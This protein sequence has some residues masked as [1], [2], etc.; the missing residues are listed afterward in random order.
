MDGRQGNGTGRRARVRDLAL[1]ALTGILTL[2][3]PD[4]VHALE[5]SPIP[6]GVFVCL[7]V[8]ALL[9]VRALG[10]LRR[11]ARAGVPMRPMRPLD[12]EPLQSPPDGPENRA[13]PGAPAPSVTPPSDRGADSAAF[14]QAGTG[15]PRRLTVWRPDGVWSS[16]ESWVPITTAVPPPARIPF[17]RNLVIAFAALVLVLVYLRGEFFF[18]YDLFVRSLGELVYWPLPWPG[19]I[20][21]PTPTMVQPDYIFLMYVALLVAFL[22]ASGALSSRR[23]TGAQRGLLLALL[24]LYLPA[25]ALVDVTYFTIQAPFSASA[26]FL[27]RGFVGGTFFTMIL[28]GTVVLPPPLRLRQPRRRD[29]R[30]I[31]TFVAAGGLSILVGAWVLFVLFVFFGLGRF[32]VPFAV[33]LLL[34]LLALVVFGLLG[35]ALYDLELAGHPKVPLSVY[36]PPVTIIIPAYNEA[37]GI[38]EAIRSADAAA[39]HYPGEVELLV[40]NDGS[41]DRTSEIARAEVAALRHMHGAVVDLPHGG[42]SNALNGALRVARGEIVVRLDA[43]SRLSPTTGFGAIVGHFNN[44]RVGGVQGMILPLQTTGWTRHLRMMEIAWAHLFLRRGLMATRTAQVVDGAFCAFRRADLLAIGGWVPWNGE[45]TEVTLRLQRAGFRMRFEPDATAY[46]DV[47]EN[48]EALRRQR[49]RW[50]R[51]G[52]FAHQRHIPALFSGRPEYGGLAIAFWF[53][54]FIRSGMRSLI[55]LYAVLVVLYL[56]TVLHLAII[57]ALLLVPRA[58]VIG[59]YLVR[60]HRARELPW[61]LIWPGA[62]AIKAHFAIESF[63]TMLPGALPEFSE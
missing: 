11:R 17:A 58:L 63:G 16:Q 3:L 41:G 9:A 13:T 57:A 14:R 5:S 22:L 42:K 56:P 2:G 38:A 52:L 55:Y 33:L 32:F 36:A 37:A 25:E 24:L 45:D 35:R 59:Y 51:G 62:A 10:Y 20:P 23:Y 26:F 39:A 54:L 61:L 8:V 44:P 49:I 47:P 60:T 46:E 12:L 43:D 19:T 15:A 29:R 40:G 21:S 4:V 7:A 18:G 50:N 31:V 48:L 27:V 1:P 30:S 6:L 34:P 28:F 53:L